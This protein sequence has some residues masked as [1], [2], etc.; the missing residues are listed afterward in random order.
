MQL[1]PLHARTIKEAVSDLS[2]AKQD[3]VF[4]PGSPLSCKF[5]IKFLNGNITVI[6]NEVDTIIAKWA[7]DTY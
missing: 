6:S 5:S 3:P 2:S 1:S 4:K 7:V